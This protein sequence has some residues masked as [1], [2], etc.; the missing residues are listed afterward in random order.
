M[1]TLFI[2][3]AETAPLAAII[4][5]LALANFIA[6]KLGLLLAVPPGLAA[7]VSPMSGVALGTTLLLGYGALPGTLLGVLA[8]HVHQILL[9][10]PDTSLETTLLAA[11]GIATGATL[12]AGAGAYLIKR[13]VGFPHPLDDERSI[14]LT[15]GFGGPIA[16]LIA[17]TIGLSPLGI[18]GSTNIPVEDWRTWYLGD[19]MGVILFLP[20]ILLI[21]SKKN[22]LWRKRQTTVGI[23]MVG[24]IALSVVVFVHASKRDQQLI[25]AKLDHKATKTTQQIQET[26]AIHTDTLEHVARYFSTIENPTHRQFVEFTE[27]IIS[28]KIGFRAMQWVPRVR[29]EQRD[30]FEKLTSQIYP[31]FQIK[32][33]D[34]E[35]GWITNSSKDANDAYPVSWIQPLEGNEPALGIDLISN[36]PRADVLK[37]SAETGKTAFSA[38]VSLVQ[39]SSRFPGILALHPVYAN[40]QSEQSLENSKGFILGVFEVNRMLATTLAKNSI[41]DTSI[42]IQDSEDN[43][44]SLVQLTTGSSPRINLTKQIHIGQRI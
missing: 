32:T 34:P 15:F 11:L 39:K 6:G 23:P 37:Q 28:N 12:Q 27:P 42:L 25:E 43:D 31:A 5:L 20:L 1:T 35:K 41:N 3:K 30:S 8:F 29:A 10:S 44:L 19:V 4:L 2:K 33:F 7:V 14:L 17:P 9:T 36:T 26:L 38:P 16:C 21:L 40:I 13:F 22:S 24:G 18:L